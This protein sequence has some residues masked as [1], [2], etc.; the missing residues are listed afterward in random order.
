MDQPNDRDSL[1]QTPLDYLLS[2]LNVPPTKL[3]NVAI[4]KV[5]EWIFEWL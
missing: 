2:N 3:A 5:D 1:G 4:D